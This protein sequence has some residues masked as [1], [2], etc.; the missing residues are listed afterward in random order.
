M[1]TCATGAERYSMRSVWSPRSRASRSRSAS[2]SPSSW[3]A[4]AR[5]ISESGRYGGRG[6]DERLVQVQAVVG[7]Q[8]IPGD[9]VPVGL[10]VAALHRESERQVVV[11]PA[12]VA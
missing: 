7:G 6:P 2:L 1:L 10:G 11:E 12:A 4:M 8:G 3:S 9:D 5:R